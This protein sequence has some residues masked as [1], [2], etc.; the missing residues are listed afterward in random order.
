IQRI[1]PVTKKSH[2]T[3]KRSIW[4]CVQNTDPE[5]LWACHES[6]DPGEV[7]CRYGEKNHAFTVASY[8][9]EE[10]VTKKVTS[11]V[12]RVTSDYHSGSSSDE[13]SSLSETCLPPTFPQNCLDRVDHY[14]WMFTY[15]VFM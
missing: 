4:M 15:V 10:N 14:A 8:F 11:A 2:P 13:D 12:E 9:S 1:S 7:C 6:V 3:N 5:L